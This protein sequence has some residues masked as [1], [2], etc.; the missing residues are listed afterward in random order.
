[1][2]RLS[3]KALGTLKNLQERLQADGY[4]KDGPNNGLTRD[5][6]DELLDVLLTENGQEE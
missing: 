2:A 5:I 1:M 6:L 3:N 4:G